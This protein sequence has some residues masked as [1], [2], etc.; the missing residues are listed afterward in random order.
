MLTSAFLSLIATSMARI[1]PCP[2]STLAAIIMMAQ[3]GMSRPILSY[4]LLVLFVHILVRKSDENSKK[5]PPSFGSN[6][7]DFETINLGQIIWTPATSEFGGF[8]H[9]L[10]YQGHDE[11]V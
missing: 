7:P 10:M 9:S 5:F 11:I 2:V 8:Q 6:V 4:S 3:L 1:A